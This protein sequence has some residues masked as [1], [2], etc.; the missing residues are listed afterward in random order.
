MI[1]FLAKYVTHSTTIVFSLKTMMQLGSQGATDL[2]MDTWLYARSF[3]HYLDRGMEQSCRINFWILCSPRCELQNLFTMNLLP[4][5]PTKHFTL[6]KHG[7]TLL[8]LLMKTIPSTKTRLMVLLIRDMNISSSGGN[9]SSTG[10]GLIRSSR[11]F[12]K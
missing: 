3:L 12:P 2:N 11:K 1:R 9:R 4:I 8:T 5:V 10:A 7:I 6:S